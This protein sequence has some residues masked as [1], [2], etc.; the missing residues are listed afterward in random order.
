MAARRAGVVA[1]STVVVT[2]LLAVLLVAWAASIG[3]GV[4]LRGDGT[5]RASVTASPTEESSDASQSEEEILDPDDSTAGDTNAFT[6]LALVLNA[7]CVVVAG[8]L[9]FRGA[10]W[11]VRV[12]R[13]R[14]RR[15]TRAR[16]EDA[17]GVEMLGTGGTVAREMLADAAAQRAVLAEGDSRNAVVACW[18]RF[19]E[20]AGAAGVE[21]HPWETSAEYTLRVLD[22]VDVDTPAVAR[23][24][25]LFREARFSEHPVTEQ[26]RAEALEALDA[27]HRALRLGSGA[28]A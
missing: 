12:R 8:Y 14:D 10:R 11:T 1:V 2:T 4:V 27:I 20:Q 16:A 22:L 19:E 23:L 3:P 17:A 24:A 9:V 6:I 26:H 21:R 7:A 13:E 18:S 28:S 5:A 15:R 25:A